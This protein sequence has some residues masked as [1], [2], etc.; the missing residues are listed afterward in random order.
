M[1]QLLTRAAVDK[2]VSVI[3]AKQHTS[4]APVYATIFLS[5]CCRKELD[6]LGGGNFLT[7]FGICVP[8]SSRPDHW[9]TKECQYVLD[10]ADENSLSW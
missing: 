1:V 10:R 2:L 4:D 7:E 3:I 6:T 5:T 8:D 9:G